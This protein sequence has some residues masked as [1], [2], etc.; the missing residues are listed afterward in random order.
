MELNRWFCYIFLFFLFAFV[1]RKPDNSPEV[2]VTGTSN[3]KERQSK[4]AMDTDTIYNKVV[5]PKPTIVRNSGAK[6]GAKLQDLS[7]A[8]EF[9]DLDH[10][11]RKRI[12]TVNGFITLQPKNT[13]VFPLA[14]NSRFPVSDDDIMHFSAIVELAYT[15]RI[16]KYVFLFVFI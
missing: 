3:F 12:T 11:I 8:V 6:V 5:H 10:V 9:V 13:L 1:Q 14:P 15:D 16:Q 4:F 7:E 2:V